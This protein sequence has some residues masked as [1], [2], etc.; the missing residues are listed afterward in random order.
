[1][2][3]RIDIPVHRIVLS[4]NKHV[5]SLGALSKHKPLGARITDIVKRT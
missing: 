5:E 4:H 3:A 1:M 2:R